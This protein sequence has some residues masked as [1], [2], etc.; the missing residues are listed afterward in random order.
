MASVRSWPAFD[1]RRSMRVSYRTWTERSL[2]VVARLGVTDPERG[3]G[4]SRGAPR[5]RSQAAFRSGGLWRVGAHGLL[6]D[7][8]AP[9]GASGQLKVA[10]VDG[11]FDGDE[12]VLPGDVV[13]V[14][15]H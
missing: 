12:V 3:S 15:L 8:G 13:G 14:D 10:A 7:L 11:G 6:V 5:H 1:R 4:G 9:A 2:R